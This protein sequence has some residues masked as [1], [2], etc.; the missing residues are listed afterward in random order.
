MPYE[1][2]GIGMVV[3]SLFRSLGLKAIVRP[4]LD[5]Y[6]M[7]KRLEHMDEHE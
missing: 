5:C 7:K 1:L 6:A 4:L 3:Y 2:K